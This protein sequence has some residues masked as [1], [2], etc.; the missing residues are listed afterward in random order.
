MAR[1]DIFRL[2]E[3]EPT[4]DKKAIKKA[5]ARLVRQYH[6][7]EQP[8][9]W[10]EIHD[11]YEAAL[12]MAEHF[13]QA[14]IT[15]AKESGSGLPETETVVESPELAGINSDGAEELDSLFEIV[16]E[17]SARQREVRREEQRQAAEKLMQ[18]IQELLADEL[19]DP[20]GWEEVFRPDNI[21]LL[22]SNKEYM[23]RFGDC[24][25]KYKIHAK[26]W[27][28][29]KE[30]LDEI[31]QYH[32]SRSEAEENGSGIQGEIDYAERKMNAA[33]Y[34]N[35][36]KQAKADVASGKRKR[37]LYA[38]AGVMAGVVIMTFALIAVLAL[39]Y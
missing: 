25:A 12:A 29:L 17:L 18:D 6:P 1:E 26:T 2:L 33:R 35:V 24:L 38:I 4:D 5:Y 20:V 23:H 28:L 15:P 37:L 7:E 30:K 32:R 3:I 11:A 39:M 31:S 14:V 16:G 22:L 19:F 21:E 36:G 9:K 8:E 13:S 10:K 34:A 27:Q